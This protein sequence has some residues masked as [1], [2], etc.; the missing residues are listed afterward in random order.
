MRST[1][2]NQLNLWVYIIIII[3]IIIIVIEM[4]QDLINW[5]VFRKNR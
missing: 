5:A 2:P 4:S 1:W 3:I